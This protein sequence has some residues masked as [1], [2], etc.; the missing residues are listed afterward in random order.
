MKSWKDHRLQRPTQ[1]WVSLPA[2]HQLHTRA[3][4]PC[5]IRVTA[6]DCDGGSSLS[7]LGLA[8]GLPLPPLTFWSS[9]LELEIGLYYRGSV[10]LRLDC[11]WERSSP[12]AGVEVNRGRAV[13]YNPW[14]RVSE[15]ADVSYEHHVLSRSHPIFGRLVIYGRNG[16]WRCGRDAMKEQELKRRNGRTEGKTIHTVERNKIRSRWKTPGE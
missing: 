13:A 16:K 12:A 7:S 6:T 15:S 14:L 4:H 9:H 8:C 1:T 3:M 10:L 11:M 5:P 2:F